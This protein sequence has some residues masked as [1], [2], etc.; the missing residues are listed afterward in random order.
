MKCEQCGTDFDLDL[1][2]RLRKVAQKATRDPACMIEAADTLELIAQKMTAPLKD[3][4]CMYQYK[5]GKVVSDLFNPDHIPEGWYDSPRS[6][7]AGALL[8]VVEPKKRGRP[9]KV[10]DGNGS[11]L[12]QLVS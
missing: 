4:W 9:K 1:I 12:N 10:D 3:P 5:D 2:S 7:K 11:G 6:A 8:D